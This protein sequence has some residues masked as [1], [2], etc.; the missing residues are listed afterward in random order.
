M[1]TATIATWLA[2][3]VV[4]LCVLPLLLA[5]ARAL[6]LEVEDE[7]AVLITRFGKLDRTLKSPGLL[8]FPS[9]LLPWMQARRVSLQRDF[10]EI[11]GVHINDARGTTVGVDLWVEFRIVDPVRATFQVADWDRAMQNLIS[12]TASAVLGDREFKQILGDR[13]ELGT[14]IKRLTESETAR[15]GIAIERVFIRDVKLLP[16]VSRLMLQTIA[17][18]LE[19]ARADVDQAGR[20]AVAQLEADT[21]VRV[22]ALIAEAKGQYPQAV[23][24]A[25]EALKKQPAVLDAYNQIYALSTLRPHRTVAFRGF[26]RDG[27]RSV[28]AAMLAPS[29]L[30]PSAH[31]ERTLAAPAHSNKNDHPPTG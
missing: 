30:T 7:E 2:G 22:A 4:G 17:A 8:V 14:S 20:L 6:T 24:R 19:R 13:T 18:Q 10:R 29:A 12:H 25:F 16:E 23:G 11:S 9:M 21:S 1:S 3:T 26:D 5:L 27:L 31:D 28:D 15:W